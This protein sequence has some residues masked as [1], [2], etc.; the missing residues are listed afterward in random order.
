MRGGPEDRAEWP[1]YGHE[2]GPEGPTI[3]RA[4]YRT[5]PQPSWHDPLHELPCNLIEGQHLLGATERNRL[6]GHAEH[7]AG[8]LVLSDGVP[9]AVANL[10]EPPRP[11]AAH[12]GEH[13]PDR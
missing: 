9:S 11:V 5:R 12:A 13:D 4:G 10:F 7:D 3:P 6:S 1:Q 8:R 2:H